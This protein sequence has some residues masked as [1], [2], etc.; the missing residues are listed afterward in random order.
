MNKSFDQRR[1][2]IKS[3]WR[4]ACDVM[5]MSGENCSIQTCVCGTENRIA[6]EVKS[7]YQTVVFKQYC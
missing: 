7:A 6:R 5:E 1:K 4:L 3:D 2:N